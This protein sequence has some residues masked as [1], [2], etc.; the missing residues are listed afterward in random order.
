MLLLSHWPIQHYHYHLQPCPGIDV[1]QDHKSLRLG[2]FLFGLQLF[3]DLQF[4]LQVLSDFF[5]HYI[6][7]PESLTDLLPSILSF[8]PISFL[9]KLHSF[10]SGFIPII[11]PPPISLTSLAHPSPTGVI[12]PPLFSAPSNSFPLPSPIFSFLSPSI[13]PSSSNT[14]SS[15]SSSILPS[16]SLLIFSPL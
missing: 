16:T 12:F 6:L 4:S 13:Y 1:S 7:L 2:G 8:V 10:P 9:C 14:N 3:L 11:L 5:S 15:S